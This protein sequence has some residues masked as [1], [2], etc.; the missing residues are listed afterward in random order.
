NLTTAEGGAVISTDPELLHRVRTFRTV[1][2]VRDRDR[3]R[4]PDEGPWHQEVH[5]FGLNLRL[6]D[7]LCALGCSQASPGYASRLSGRAS[8]RCGT[9]IRYAFWTAAAARSS[10]GCARPASACRS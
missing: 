4:H 10:S 8:T 6:P 7:L 2:L 5:E 1:G 3:L 9:S